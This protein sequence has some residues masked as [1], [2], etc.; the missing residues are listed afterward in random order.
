MRARKKERKKL[1]KKESKKERKKERKYLPNSK[2]LWFF[3]RGS[4]FR[5]TGQGS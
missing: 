2:E 3:S 5:F 1:R 4:A